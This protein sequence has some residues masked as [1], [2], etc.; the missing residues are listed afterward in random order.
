MVDLSSHNTNPPGVFDGAP[1]ELRDSS[2]DRD[3]TALASIRAFLEEFGVRPTAEAWSA[4]GMT[5]RFGRLAVAARTLTHA[6]R[7]LVTDQQSAAVNCALV[8]DDDPLH[9]NQG[10]DR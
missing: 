4:T 7:T 10:V 6:E 5:P 2:D 8:S 9:A 3:E 1:Y